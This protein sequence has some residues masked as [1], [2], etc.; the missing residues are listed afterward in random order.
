MALRKFEYLIRDV[1]FE[2]FTDHEN[3]VYLNTPPSNKV[4]RWKL[5]IQEYD[6]SIYWINGELNVVADGL[7]RLTDEVPTTADNWSEPMN[8]DE[9]VQEREVPRKPTNDIETA[10]RGT[11]GNGSEPQPSETSRRKTTRKRN[12]KVKMNLEVTDL[13][14]SVEEVNEHRDT[15][16]VISDVRDQMA[17][18]RNDEDA[19]RNVRMLSNGTFTPFENARTEPLIHNDE[20]GRTTTRNAQNPH[21][22]TINNAFEPPMNDEIPMNLID[23]P[24]CG[25]T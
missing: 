19:D 14:R 7:S 22:E 9:V 20:E 5:A 18:E 24:G 23:E 10:S 15:S 1:P 2:L 4:L 12:Q 6:C 13:M 17:V 8:I 21:A 11:V 16:T 3:L 25:V